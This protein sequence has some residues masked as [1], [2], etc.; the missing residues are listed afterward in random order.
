MIPLEVGEV[1]YET[2]KSKD[3]LEQRLAVSRIGGRSIPLPESE[4]PILC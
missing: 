2:G 1:L 3:L 4:L